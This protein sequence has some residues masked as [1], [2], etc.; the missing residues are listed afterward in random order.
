MNLIVSKI[1]DSKSKPKLI[2]ISICSTTSAH[3]S[4]YTF[5][6]AE[7][8]WFYCPNSPTQKSCVPLPDSCSAMTLIIV[9]FHMFHAS[10]A[11]IHCSNFQLG[12]T[13]QK[14]PIKLLFVTVSLTICF[15]SV[16]T[17]FYG[18]AFRYSTFLY[19][20]SLMDFLFFLFLFVFVVPRHVWFYQWEVFFWGGGMLWVWQKVGALLC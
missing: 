11:K 14:I 10:E 4:E 18:I 7:P 9:F 16:D 17:R 20:N 3:T 13:E 8:I 2:S 15:Y 5:S 6:V 12:N 1:S 19:S